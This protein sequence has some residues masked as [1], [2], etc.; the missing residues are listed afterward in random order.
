[1]RASLAIGALLAAFA[2]GCAAPPAQSL[3]K[4][5]DSQADVW[6]EAALREP[7]GPTYAY[8]E[9][10]LP[11][12]RYVDAD[13]HHY[14]IVLSAPGSTVKGRLVSN[15]SAINALARQPNWEHEAGI[16]V[17]VLVGAAREA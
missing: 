2:C 8:F 15:G 12:L 9:R 11:P 6:G 16:P 3:Q 13:F 4:V 10:L 14:P 1:M 7:G 5:F 17:R